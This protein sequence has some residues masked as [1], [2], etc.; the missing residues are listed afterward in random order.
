MAGQVRLE[1]YRDEESR[2]DGSRSFKSDYFP[3]EKVRLTC[4]GVVLPGADQG[5]V[6]IVPWHLVRQIATNEET[7][8]AL[9]PE[10]S[11]YAQ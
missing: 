8:K 1:I 5:S 2:P 4:Y 9:I 7:M 11:G 3:L 6:Y 10:H